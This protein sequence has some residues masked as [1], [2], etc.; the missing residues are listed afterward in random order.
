[1]FPNSLSWVRRSGRASAVGLLVLGVYAGALSAIAPATAS[2]L[3]KSPVDT[4]LVMAAEYSKV[5]AANPTRTHVR[6][7]RTRVTKG[8]AVRLTGKV[9]HGKTLVRRDIVRLQV[10]KG[11]AWTYMKGKR[12][13]AAG[14]VTFTVQPPRTLTYRLYYP[15]VRNLA[16]SV[17]AKVTIKVVA[18][19]KTSSASVSGKRAKVIALARSL[20]GRPYSFGAAGPRA[21][22]CSGF[23]QY[24]FRKVGVK[25][26]HQA[27]AQKNRGVRISRASARPGD[28]VLFL[29][30]GHA[31]HVGIYAGGNYMY[32]SPRPG[33]RTGKHKIWSSNVIFRRVL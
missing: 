28:L 25:L 33:L 30:G 26:P 11:G 32:D 24:V 18:A 31:Y 19:A 3:A 17:S 5:A 4:P 13:S 10:R 6:A 2:T 9:T 15:G 22:D 14:V 29:S 7:T 8:S 20:S 27:N 16:S 1:V 12:L 23:T 21:F